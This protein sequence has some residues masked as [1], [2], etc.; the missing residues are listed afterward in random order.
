MGTESR[1]GAETAERRA[2]RALYGRAAA[3][4]EVEVHPRTH[5]AEALVA[6]WSPIEA[7]P[8]GEA[9]SFEAG[10][11]KMRKR[12]AVVVAAVVV[13]VALVLGGRLA[14]GSSAPGPRT[15]AAPQQ[16]SVTSAAGNDAGGRSVLVARDSGARKFAAGSAVSAGEGVFRY[17]TAAGDTFLGIA[18]R[19]HVC[20]A[21]LNA[22]R[23]LADQGLMLT[24]GTPITVKL[25][26]WPTTA[27]GTA[28]C[29]WDH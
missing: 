12:F 10:R 19:F 13:L 18:S 14:L 9:R 27:D 6:D 8:G 21:D 1:G 17:T 2:Q 24:A 15:S 23:P 26:T 20:T 3:R 11:G 29:V 5:A 7:P 4:D 16:S 22:G 25:G 28:D